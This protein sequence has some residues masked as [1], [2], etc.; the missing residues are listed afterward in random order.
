MGLINYTSLV[1]LAL[2]LGSYFIKL[3]LLY[4]KDKIHANVLGKAGKDKKTHFAEGFV[5]ITSFAGFSIWFLE[6]MF[7]DYVAKFT[8]RFYLSTLSTYAGLILMALGI[9]FFALAVVF[10]KSSWRVGIDKETK[11]ELVTDGIYKFSRNPAFVGFNL[12]FIGLCLTFPDVL[13]FVAMVV[14]IIAFHL[15]I[16]QEERHLIEVF[17]KEY[18]GYKQKTPRYLLLF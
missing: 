6:A 3:I 8:G 11:T 2:F 12:A 15:L 13:T 17:G 16:L 5:K 4:K 10:M 9:L 14:N 1:F 7:S 18:A